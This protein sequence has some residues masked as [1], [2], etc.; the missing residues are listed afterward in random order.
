LARR[1]EN[2]VRLSATP[3]ETFELS[4]LGATFDIQT[5]FHHAS[6]A[7]DFLALPAF[8]EIEGGICSGDRRAVYYLIRHLRPRAI[9]EIGTHVCASTVFF[10]AAQKANGIG[11]LTTVDVKDCRRDDIAAEF[12][13]SDSLSYMRFTPHRFDFVFLDGDHGARTVYR[14]LAAALRILSP[15]G[16]VLLHDY[17]PSATPISGPLLGMARV[18]AEN[19][20]IAV[21]PLGN[22]PWPRAQ[23]EDAHLTSL[24][25]V[26]QK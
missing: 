25:I 14:E 5:V 8:G 18:S 17:Y 22:L 26:A 15:G 6:Y 13:I 4:R 9:L 2:K 7:A 23:G 11:T 1:A 24:A 3:R 12:V 19:P 10:A 16:Y 21:L 20:D